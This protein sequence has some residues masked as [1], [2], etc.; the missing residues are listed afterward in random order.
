MFCDSDP[1]VWFSGDGGFAYGC[2]D[3]EQE[4]YF[5]AEFEVGE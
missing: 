5:Y 3:H 2:S 4:A 1:T